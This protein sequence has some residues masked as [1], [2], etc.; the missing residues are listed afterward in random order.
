VS[1]FSDV[2][3]VDPAQ[4]DKIVT[5]ALLIYPAI[6]EQN[7]RATLKLA[8]GNADR[9][10]PHLKTAKIP[11]VIQML[12]AAGV[13]SV[14]CSTTLELKVACEEGAV[15]VLLAFP[16][17]GA[18]ARRVLQIA[19]EY[20]SARISVLIESAEQLSK[21]QDSPVGVFLDIN[22]GMNRTGLSQDALQMMITLAKQAGSRFRGLHY[23]DGHMAG[24][25]AAER[26]AKAH[27]GYRRLLRI[28]DALK[29]AGLP[30]EEIVTSGTPAAPYALSFPEFNHARFVHRVSPG[31]VVYNDMTSL[32]Q[33]PGLGYAPAALVLSTV[34]SRPT[35]NTVTC[36]AGHKS[37]S[38]DAGVPTCAVLYG[39]EDFRPLRPSEEHLPIHCPSPESLPAIGTH[40]Y[41]L[42]R[43]VCPTVNN[44]DQALFVREGM[45]TLENISARGHETLLIEND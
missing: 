12:L 32:E 40:L 34:V 35:A 22:S 17:A 2:Y 25:P 1:L 14:K 13:R 38:A 16:V 43:H 9:W 8:G 5:P 6:V 27:E 18:N 29:S 3:R 20:Q 42:P 10:R 21:W 39:G 11:A 36:D 28:A 41:L 45:I 26:E 31:T 24:V 4:A 37:V 33:L 44:F 15:D 30:C 23:Y 7:I 19:R